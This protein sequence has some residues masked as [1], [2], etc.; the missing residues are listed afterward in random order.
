MNEY[1]NAKIVNI[2]KGKGSRRHTIYA[3]LRSATGVLLIAA[4][5]EYITKALAE[6]L[7]TAK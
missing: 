3:E 1:E 7:P 6:R 5:L 4:T 2:H